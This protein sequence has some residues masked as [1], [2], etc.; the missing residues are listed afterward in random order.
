MEVPA[1]VIPEGSG[2]VKPL[3]GVVIFTFRRFQSLVDCTRLYAGGAPPST[4]R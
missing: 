2:P 3:L 4:R 1:L